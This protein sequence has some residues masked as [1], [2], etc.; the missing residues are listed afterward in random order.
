MRV[1]KGVVIDNIDPT[2]SGMFSVRVDSHK[3]PVYVVYT[4]PFYSTP[5]GNEQKSYTG[6][7]LPPKPGTQVLIAQEE[8]T[9]TWYYI[10]AIVGD[11]GQ[12]SPQPETTK[13]TG[14]I[15]HQYKA[16]HP[17][18][19][20]SAYDRKPFP[21]KFG[22]ETVNGANLTFSE[23]DSKVQGGEKYTRLQSEVGMKLVLADSGRQVILDN[24]QQDGL[25]ITRDGHKGSSLGPRDAQLKANGNAYILSD[26]GAAEIKSMGRDVRVVAKG[27][28]NQFSGPT[29]GEVYVES[30][31]N[32]I[33]IKVRSSTGRIFLDAQ[34]SESL[35]QVRA[36]SG[37]VSVFTDGSI[38][39]NAGGEVNI[40]ADGD[41]NLQGSNIHLN[42]GETSGK[43]DPTLNNRDVEEGS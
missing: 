20:D 18:E 19:R 30:Q 26:C 37:G 31:N 8:D 14:T 12:F 2:K 6:M 29:D 3:L 10:G 39:L 27:I 21:Q 38:D 24:G 42:K 35:V 43:T 9:S 33:V 13:L 16:Y 1:K 11:T 32:D 40:N 15:D 22:I 23:K 25:V 4:S 17:S 7:F 28:P 5:Q 36:G 34:G 41:I